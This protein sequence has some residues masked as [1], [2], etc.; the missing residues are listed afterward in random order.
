MD[1]TELLRKLVSIQSVFPHEN[2][3]SDYL[4]SLLSDIG[5]SVETVDT[6]GRKNIVATYGESR[7]YLCLYGHMDTV[8]PNTGMNEPFKLKE[9]DGIGR[10]LGAADMK[11]GV[12]AIITAARTA[13]R[14]RLPLKVVLGVDE[15]NI[16]EGAHAIIDSG[17]LKDAG[18]LI[19]GESGGESLNSETIKEPFTVCYGRKGRILFDATISGV[20]SHAANK[21]EGI[22][23]IVKAA[24]FACAADKMSFPEHETLGSTDIVVQSIVSNA[25]SF[26]IPDA[27]DIS[28]SV[29]TTPNIKSTSVL[30]KLNDFCKN[31]NININI[32]AHS[33]ATPYG[34][35]YEVDRQD[36]FVQKLE[37]QLFKPNGV[38]PVYAASV[39]DENVFA[40]R[41]GIPVIS[42]G[43]V[44]GG[45]HALNEWIRLDS[46]NATTK[47]YEKAIALYNS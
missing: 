30:K 24:E 12:A 14:N 46:L 2:E 16:S 5:F 47:A 44:S 40:N 36:G 26:S 23:A 3:I 6:G 15:E 41:L 43:P 11:G 34:E 28:F 19:S 4:S 17:L 13:V 8:P 39:A 33:R 9:K 22:N 25:D 45:F 10:G 38:K 35:S 21:K 1:A 31:K 7:K 32:R 37:S 27:C 18:F 42:M 20:R 29:I